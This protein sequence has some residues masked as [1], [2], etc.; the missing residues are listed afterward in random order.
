MELI[1]QQQPQPLN[2]QLNNP[3]RT[4]ASLRVKRRALKQA[5]MA[6]LVVRST[7]VHKLSKP[8][9]RPNLRSSISNRGLE[10]AVPKGNSNSRKRQP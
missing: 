8:H 1:Y 2:T 6:R 4:K 7:K 5:N 10:E 9:N 3:L